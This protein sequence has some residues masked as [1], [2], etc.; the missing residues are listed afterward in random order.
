M[1]LT[2]SIVSR[3]DLPSSKHEYTLSFPDLKGGLNLSAPDTEIAA[4]E[5][6]EMQNMLFYEGTLNSRDGQVFLDDEEQ[7]TL[8]AAFPEL[9]HDHLFAHIGTNI[10]CRTVTASADGTVYV[11]NWETLYT[12]LTGNQGTFLLY[13]EYLLYK[14]NGSFVKI[15]FSSPSAFSCEPVTGYVPVTYINCAASN[16]AGDS[17]Q[18][19]NRLSSDCTLWYNASGGTT[20]KLPVQATWITSVY[21]DGVEL[22]SGWSYNRSNR[23]VTFTTAPPVTTPATNNTVW[24]TYHLSNS[25]AYNAV[26]SC[27]LA[28]VYGGVDG[29]C[30]V[31]GN[32]SAQKNAFFWS[33]NNAYGMDLSYFP[34]NQYQLAGDSHSAIT[35]FGRQQSYLI[36]FKED[37]V[38]RTSISTET[39]DDRLYISMPYT[40]INSKVGCDVKGS[41]QLIENNLVFANKT[42]GVFIINNSSPA[43]EN[44]IVCISGKV[45]GG[46][47]DGLITDLQQA[48]YACSYDDGYKYCLTVNGHS[49]LWDYSISSQS[50]PSWFYCTGIAAKEY[51][52]VVPAGTILL[53]QIH[54]DDIGRLTQFMR[55][56]AD[57]GQPI[58]KIYRFA[59]TYF[60]TYANLKDAVDVLLAMR[61]ATNTNTKLTYITDYETRDDLTN[62][63]AY[64]W[65]LV[66]RN[67]TYRCLKGRRF[68]QIFKR[69]PMCRHIRHF[70]MRLYNN[71]LGE[72]MSVAF[73][74][75]VYKIMGK[76]R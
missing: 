24:I 13:D 62:L 38:G 54:L 34:M 27:D 2:P 64:S 59:S 4:N 29:L 51:I 70:T 52:S 32:S 5:S 30:V 39:I 9:W 48:D 46:L 61:A 40:P 16:G 49:W 12:K 56:Y 26:M 76:E 7:G 73:A 68:P 31:L 18:P 36:I 35:G 20:Y 17:Y 14:N 67:L 41:I 50:N 22:T 1:S 43:Y 44:N 28:T 58:E 75:I 33:G 3:N 57:Y 45:N 47:K 63:A 23:T 15:L 66:P 8:F 25:D 19:E 71:N 55:I 42:R 21:V 74:Q 69:R 11:G 72:D 6:G 60:N 37:S 53:M 65:Q 10:M